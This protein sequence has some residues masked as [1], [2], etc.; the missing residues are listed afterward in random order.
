[1]NCPDGEIGGWM[2]GSHMRWS[3]RTSFQVLPPSLVRDRYSPRKKSLGSFRLSKYMMSTWPLGVT[4]IQGWN[5]SWFTRIGPVYVL[6]PSVDLNITMSAP[7]LGSP[8][9]SSSARRFS[10]SC[11]SCS[12]DVPSATGEPCPSC[13]AAATYTVPLLSIP[14]V[15][16]D[17]LRNDWRSNCVLTPL[18]V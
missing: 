4:A 17:R 14:V 2:R 6:P 1:M 5:W 16:S 11:F 18:I 13:E 15:G 12:I 3:T 7:V 8:P 9:A 10:R